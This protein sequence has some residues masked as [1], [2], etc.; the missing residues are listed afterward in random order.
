MS[1]TIAHVE[2]E[3]QRSDRFV[4]KQA[5]TQEFSK[6]IIINQYKSKY[7]NSIN[8]IANLIQFLISSTKYKVW[9]YL[10]QYIADT[11]KDEKIEL[12]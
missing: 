1:G 8:S 11:L 9:K 6:I 4:R 2:H 7:K 5:S 3:I 12:T 10:T